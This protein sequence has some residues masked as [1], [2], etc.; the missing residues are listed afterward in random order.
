M[1]VNLKA[2][3]EITEEPFE[4]T[5]L[6]DNG[7]DSGDVSD[8]TVMF[9]EGADYNLVSGSTLSTLFGK[10][11]KLISSLKTIAFSGAYSDATGRPQYNVTDVDNDTSAQG[12]LEDMTLVKEGN[13]HLINVTVNGESYSDGFY[14]VPSGGN[15]GQVLKKHSNSSGDVEWADEEGG[16]SDLTATA[17]VDANT[18]TPSVEVSKTG[19]NID[20]AFHNLKGERGATGATGPQGETG[21]TGPQGEQGIQGIQGVQGNDGVGIS[22]IAYKETDASGNNVYTI[23]LTNSSTYD[24][25]ANRGPQGA[26]GATGA[27]GATGASGND[28]V[29]ISTITF[30]E[31][32]ASGNNVYTITLTNGNTYDFTANRGPQG[33]QGATGAT[34]ATGA[35]VAQGGATGQFLSKVDGTDYNTQWSNILQVPSASGASSGDVLS[36]DGSGGYA[37]AT[38]SG[39]GGGDK[40][41]RFP[42]N[43]NYV[44]GSGS[45][46]QMSFTLTLDGTVDSTEFNDANSSMYRM[47]I[48]SI[49]IPIAY[50]NSNWFNAS[51]TFASSARYYSN[52]TRE[53]FTAV[54]SCT[55]TVNSTTLVNALITI[56]GTITL[57]NG[58]ATVNLTVNVGQLIMQ[59]VLQGSGSIKA[60]DN[61]KFMRIYG[62]PSLVL[63]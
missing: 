47:L 63:I 38:P 62:R 46:N 17:S 61:L 28:G 60:S 7:G 25:T 58:V 44:E 55:F 48:G 45:G 40:V 16:A 56:S 8:S 15:S 42:C 37:W 39:G 5:N 27:T 36:A 24:F 18:G 31:T 29:G 57:S 12:D 23:T 35:G 41:L 19:N 34:G 22:N 52:N 51:L 11:K 53:L 26:Q 33:A 13:A 59:E 50:D 1:S 21:A 10:I 20:F 3:Y 9:S 32:D 54:K 30:K 6:F 49:G 43:T 14:S 2:G 4:P